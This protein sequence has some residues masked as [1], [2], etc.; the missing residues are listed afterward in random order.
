MAR[1]TPNSCTDFS[2]TR[3]HYFGE[4]DTGRIEEI[5]LG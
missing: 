3:R 4:E 1:V 2:P 5:L